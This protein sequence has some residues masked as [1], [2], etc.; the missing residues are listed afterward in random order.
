MKKKGFTL[1]ELLAAIV[2]LVV[3][4]LVAVP[5]IMD[6]IEK[7][8]RNAFK[9]SVYQAFQEIQY[10]LVK[11]NLNEI[12]EEGIEVKDIEFKN[13]IFISGRLILSQSGNIKAANV[14][15]GKYCAVGEK[16]ALEIFD[17][18]CDLSVPTCDIS[19]KEQAGVSGWYGSNPTVVMNTMPVK[20]GSLFFGIGPSEDYSHTVNGIGKVGTAEYKTTENGP[21]TVYCYVQNISEV[22]GSNEVSVKIDKT[23]PASVQLR[24]SVTGKN[25]TVIASGVDDESGIARYQFSKDGGKTWTDVQA[26][27]TYVFQNLDPVLHSL[28]VR[29]YNGTYMEGKKNNV[30]KESDVTQVSLAQL[31]TPTYSYNP[32]DWTAGNVDVT[33]HFNKDGA[34]LIKPSQNVVS[35][36]DAVTCSNVYN[37]TYTC[38]GDTTKNL[39]AGVWYQVKSNPTLTF[40]E[41]GSIIAQVSDGMNYKTGSSFNISNI[42]RVKPVANI[43]EVNVVAGIDGWYQSAVLQLEKKSSG[44]SGIGAMY[45]CVTSNDTCN[46]TTT[47]STENRI[48]IENNNV[49]HKICGKIVSR[50]G[51]ES[52]IICS[53][54]YKVDNIPP[55]AEF[56]MTGVTCKDN[57][58]IRPDKAGDTWTLSGT[59]NITKNYECQDKAGNVYTASRTYRYNS[60]KTGSNTCEGGYE[61]QVWSSCATG[62]NTCKAGYTQVWNNCKTGSPNA[63]VAGTKQVYNACKTTQN[64]CQGAYSCSQGTLQSD[65]TKCAVFASPQQNYA[66]R[67]FTS[68]SACQSACSGLGGQCAVQAGTNYVCKYPSGKTCPSGYTLNSSGSSCYKYIASTYNSCATGSQNECV[69]GYDTVTDPCASTTNTCQGGYVDGAWSD[70]ATGSNTCKEG[71]INSNWNDCKT[72]SNTCQGGFE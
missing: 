38:D 72:G 23:A 15:D 10:Y 14:S 65:Q 62:E 24:Y 11:H 8:R 34:Y 17:G 20:S 50:T 49:G 51:I 6:T 27:N 22:R 61:S 41:N 3:L 69:P 43:K 44:A 16:D 66:T 7:S 58:E 31:E 33:V 42:D 68:Q 57:Y 46:P 26:S 71:Y 5:T 70:C 32:T 37:G 59:S 29:A 56:S 64:T 63:C 28:K 25:I 30:Y 53:N 39:Q 47:V 13:N 45:Y 1:I 4:A 9:D 52:D 2:I 40:T 12:P 48:S 18:A 55:T 67:T 60:C 21:V 36:I 19:V 54:I 35:N